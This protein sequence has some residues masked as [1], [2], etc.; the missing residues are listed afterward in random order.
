MV[1]W[2]QSKLKN[3]PKAWGRPSTREKAAGDVRFLMKLRRRSV[4]P[5]AVCCSG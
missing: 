3:S 1:K 5:D 4:L 2:L